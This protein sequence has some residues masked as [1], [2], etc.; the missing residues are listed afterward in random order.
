MGLGQRRLVCFVDALDECNEEQVR[1]M[2]TYFEDLGDEATNDGIHLQICFSSRHYPHIEIE[3]GLRLTLEDQ[4]G[5][6]K[7]LEKYVRSCLRVDTR[8]DA[9]EIKNGVLKKANGVFMWVVLVVDILNKEYARGRIFAARRKLDEIL[10]RMSELSKDIVRRDNDHME[11]L[12][13]CIQWI[14]YAKWPLTREEFYFGMLCRSPEDLSV[15]D[16]DM[17]TNSD[18]D[19]AVVRSSKGLAEIT[20]SKVGTVQFIH[21]S[22]RDFFIKDNGLQEIWPEIGEKF[23]STG[24]EKLK[25]CCHA[26]I[27]FGTTSHVDIT[28]SLSK[29]NSPE[30]KELRQIISKELPFAEYATKHVLYHANAAATEI[31]QHDFL[32]GFSLREWIHLNNLFEKHEIRRYT[33]NANLVYILAE[34]NLIK[35]I[36]TFVRDHHNVHVMGERYQLPMF[37]ALSNGHLLAAKALLG[38]AAKSYLRRTVSSGGTRH[39]FIGLSKTDM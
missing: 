19:L 28:E 31:F 15:F 6:E 16:P 30:A 26:Y 2:V 39:H 3:N 8:S 29:A 37:A 20:K 35:L 32:K 34:K 11:D 10:S 14:L 33:P 25:Q 18:L 22:V 13:L 27:N 38:Q 21:E 36:E 5:H 12:L 1:E 7:D 24:H 4:P 23:Q 17:I 9:E